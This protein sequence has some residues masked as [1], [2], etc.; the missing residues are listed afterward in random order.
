MPARFLSAMVSYGTYFSSP[1]TSGSGSGSITI[2]PVAPDVWAIGAVLFMASANASGAVLGMTIDG[3]PMAT[4]GDPVMWDSNKAMLQAF[5]LED[6]PTGDLLAVVPSFELGGGVGSGIGPYDAIMIPVLVTYSGVESAGETTDSTGVGVDYKTSVSVDSVAEAHR[7]VTIHGAGGTS[8]SK[9]SNALSPYDFSLTARAFG[10]DPTFQGIK[11][12]L[13]DA[14][15]AS[16]VTG[17]VTENPGDAWCG[18]VGFNLTPAVVTGA[19]LLT[20][21][22]GV[23]GSGAFFRDRTPDDH[24]YWMIPA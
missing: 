3:T 13:Q 1:A 24:R 22:M 20:T 14:A 19:A 4:H 12:A 2:S 16:T 5:S 23:L 9:F 15:G 6:A 17:S 10:R 7:V 21:S 8:F 18:S 11:L